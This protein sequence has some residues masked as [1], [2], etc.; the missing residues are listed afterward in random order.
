MPYETQQP[1]SRPGPGENRRVTSMTPCKRRAFMH[2][3]PAHGDGSTL[4]TPMSMSTTE[5]VVPIRPFVIIGSSY[6]PFRVTAGHAVTAALIPPR[7]RLCATFAVGVAAMKAGR[8]R[9]SSGSACHLAS[10]LFA[11]AVDQDDQRPV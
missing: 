4:T 10:E 8:P 1:T 7:P 5:K 11:N 3:P 9:A 6:D 2:P